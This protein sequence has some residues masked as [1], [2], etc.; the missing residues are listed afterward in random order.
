M[1]WDKC[2]TGYH[3]HP[4]DPHSVEIVAHE[5]RDKGWDVFAREPA[6]SCPELEADRVDD[7]HIFI[8]SIDSQEWVENLA[9]EL[10][11][12][13]G[14][15]YKHE[16]FYRES[17]GRRVI[18]KIQSHLRKNGACHIWVRAAGDGDWELVIRRKDFD[19]A[20]QCVASN[21]RG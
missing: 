5:R 11:R 9:Y 13:L 8:A 20:A 15:P 7:D 16:V 3:V 19:L 1:D 2:Y 10:D 6:G 17:G 12:R 21:V 18:G 14:D 4:R